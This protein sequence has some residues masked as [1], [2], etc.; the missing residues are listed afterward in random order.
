MFRIPKER[1]W[2]RLLTQ[3]GQAQAEQARQAR[4]GRPGR[5]GRQTRAEAVMF[6]IL[7][8]SPDGATI[9]IIIFSV[10]FICISLQSLNDCTYCSPQYT[11]YY[12]TLIRQFL[13][14]SGGAVAGLG[15]WQQIK[16]KFVQTYL[17]DRQLMRWSSQQR[18][19]KPLATSTRVHLRFEFQ[20][21]H[22]NLKV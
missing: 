9:A 19:I 21:R 17:I 12:V 20:F 2:T 14:S 22:F 11:T 15:Q 1:D 3:A 16:L 4:V 8:Q 10:T 7:M 18:D 6:A 13:C 5:P